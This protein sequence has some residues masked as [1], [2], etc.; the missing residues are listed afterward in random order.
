MTHY[1]KCHGAT[2][3]FATQN[4]LD[5]KV[6]GHCMKKQRPGIYLCPDAVEAAVPAGKHLHAIAE[7][8]ANQRA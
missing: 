5:G 8:Y 3:P 4:V 1:L 2:T 6:I 7:I